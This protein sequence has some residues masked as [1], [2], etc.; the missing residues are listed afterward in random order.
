MK[1]N[2]VIYDRGNSSF[3][4]LQPG[5]IN[6]DTVLSGVTWFHISAI[7]P[8]LNESI[9]AVCMEAVKAAASKNI[10]ISIDLNY[11]ARLW[12]YG[13]EPHEVMPGIVKYC[14]VIMGNV[15]A[16]EK[17]LGVPLEPGF[18]HD[19]ATKE[20]YLHQAMQ[21][22]NMIQQQFP[23][24]KTIANTFR[25]DEQSGIRYF[26]TL[27]EAGNDFHSSTYQS[28]QITDKVGSGDCFMGGLIYGLYK[29]NQ[30]N[31][32]IEYAAAAAFGKLHE[33]GDTTSNS[34]E[35]IQKIIAA[36]G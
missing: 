9:T 12:K 33:L 19:G 23:K 5:D 25:F 29:N 7:S 34:V 24:C 6:W 22:A 18:T 15:W 26:A 31:D 1:H 36:N 32:I 35:E 21:T 14:N 4:S 28:A 13:K 10:T 8:A 30:P 16:A 17:L 20:T 3:A 2:A 11:R 27:R